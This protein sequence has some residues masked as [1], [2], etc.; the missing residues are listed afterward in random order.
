MKFTKGV[1]DGLPIGIGYFAV[2]F[3][4]G[5]NA[6]SLLHSWVLATL[7]SMTNLTSAGQFAGL[8]IWRLR[9][10]RLSRWP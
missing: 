8:N 2:S 7:I 9:R 10:G 1:K 6:G 4:F 5:I 3:A